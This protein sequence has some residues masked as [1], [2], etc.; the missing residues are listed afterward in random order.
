MIDFSIFPRFKDLKH[1]KI[2][3]VDYGKT[4]IGLA[5]F[6]PGLTPTTSKAG[7]IISKNKSETEI[8]KEL[9]DI[10]L[11]EEIDAIVFGLP[12][13]AQG[14]DTDQ[15]LQIRQFSNFLKELTD[16]DFYFQDE[17]LSTKS[18]E[19]RMRN[20]AEYNF[21][22]DQQSIDEVSAQIILED[23]LQSPL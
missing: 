4:V 21:R 1:K 22:V 17:H 19:D 6:I 3:A 12:L 15:S 14:E 5:S 11:E 2:L 23:F 8:L 10:I 20:S 13:N 9:K 18:A 16:L 7:R